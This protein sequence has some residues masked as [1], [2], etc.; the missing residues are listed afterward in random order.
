[1]VKWINLIFTSILNKVLPDYC[2]SEIFLTEIITFTDIKNIQKPIFTSFLLLE[3]KKKWTE[4]D[5]FLKD[6]TGF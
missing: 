4:L 2:F 6:N 1:M 3:I 5:D